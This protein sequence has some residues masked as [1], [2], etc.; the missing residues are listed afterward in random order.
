[1][2]HACVLVACILT[3][4]LRTLD[5]SKQPLLDGLFTH[6]STVLSLITAMQLHAGFHSCLFADC[7]QA[8]GLCSRGRRSYRM[9]HVG[10]NR[11]SAAVDRVAV[12]C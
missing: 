2:G 7:C 9:P 8:A 12:H 11:L 6:G 1:M 3:T 10:R 4:C 5:R